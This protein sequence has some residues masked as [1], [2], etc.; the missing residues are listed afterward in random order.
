M[1]VCM[2]MGT[3]VRVIGYECECYRMC[4]SASVRRYLFA[5]MRA[6]VCIHTCEGVCGFVCVYLCACAYMNL[7]QGQL[8]VRHCRM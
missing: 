4:V 2:G 8:Q 5:C 3:S 6:I 1:S 7:R